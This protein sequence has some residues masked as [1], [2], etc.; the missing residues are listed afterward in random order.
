MPGF[1]RTKEDAWTFDHDQRGILIPVRS[2]D[3]QIQGLQ[4]RRDNVKKRKFR[5]ISSADR[6]DGC[7][8]ESWTHLSGSAARTII[9][10]EG[11]MKADVIHA[12]SGDNV[13]SVPGVNALTQ[14]GKTLRQLQGLGLKRIMT[15]FDMDMLTNPHVQNGY[16]NLLALLEGIGLSYGSYLWDSRYKGLDDYIWECCMQKKRR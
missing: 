11:P 12:L 6:K 7:R 14:L 10:T 3:G 13:L 1:F 4:L 9:L 2:V 16:R 15:A 8:A 5:W